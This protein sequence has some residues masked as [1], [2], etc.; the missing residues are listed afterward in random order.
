MAA[1]KKNSS[2]GDQPVRAGVG[3][4][5]A[6]VVKKDKGLSIGSVAKGV[7]GFVAKRSGPVVAAD[8]VRGKYNADIKKEAK[9][10]AG[11]LGRYSTPAMAV[12]LATGK[13][14]LTNSKVRS[15][16]KKNVVTDLGNAAT[17]IGAAKAAPG[18]AKA[19][20]SSGGP[21][22]IANAVTGKKV[23]VHGSP[24]TKIKSIKPTSGSPGAP[25]ETVGWGWNPARKGS[26][27]YLVGNAQ[28]YAKKKAERLLQWSANADARS[29][30][31][32][33]AAD[34][35]KDFLSLGE[36]IKVGHHSEKRHRALIERNHNRMGKSIEEQKKAEY[37]NEKA[38]YW[39]SQESVMNLS[40]PE[41]IEFY[42]HKLEL[43]KSK[44][45][46]LKDNP[47]ERS[48]SMSLQYAN[49]EVKTQ[50][51]NLKLAIILWGE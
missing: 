22:R 48:H 42:E 31:L 13:S 3:K 15:E 14:V 46:N 8:L 39:K 20:K 44:H 1:K 26:S 49:K 11:T 21:A 34:E 27:Q 36:P 51:E 9:S 30:A 24:T 16:Y 43:A 50:E 33:A 32:W 19:I 17:V 38:S 41:C 23:V 2:R 45:Q 28:E 5:A 37:L 25:T 18:V 29:N 40:M 35:G 4:K 6:S 47:S 10:V 7:A 12:R